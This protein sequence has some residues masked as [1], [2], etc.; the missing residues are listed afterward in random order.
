M[1]GMAL[2]KNTKGI[3]NVGIGQESIKNNTIGDYNTSVGHH[4][5]TTVT[6]G[7]KNVCLGYNSNVSSKGATNQIVIGEGAK[8]H[9]NNIAVIGNTSCT[10]WHPGATGTVDLVTIIFFFLADLAICFAALRT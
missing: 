8:G 5:M 3:G 2:E 9:G 6:T 1:G 4:S 7:T 10:A